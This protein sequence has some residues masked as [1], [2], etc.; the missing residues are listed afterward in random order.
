MKSS[1][2]MD[3]GVYDRQSMG[4]SYT[5]TTADEARVEDLQKGRLLLPP[6]PVWVGDLFDWT[7]DPFNDRNWRFQRHTL[8]WLMPLVHQSKLGDAGASLYTALAKSWAADNPVDDPSAP[9]TWTDMAAGTRATTLALGTRLIGRSDASWYADLL[10]LHRDWLVEE[11]N[12]GS[13]NHALHQHQGLLVVASTIRD[14][15]AQTLAVQ[16]MTEQFDVAFDDQGA[17]DEG[18]TAYHQ[19]NLRWWTDAWERVAREGLPVPEHVQSRLKK[20]SETLAHMTLPSGRLV[21]I[22]D[23]VQTRVR[24]GL[25]PSTDWLASG[26]EK[27]VQPSSKVRVLDRGY[28]LSRSGWRRDDSFVATRFGEDARYSHTHEDR[29]AVWFHSRGVTWL[30]D[31]GFRSYQNKDPRFIYLKGE[32]AHNVPFIVGL[33]ADI[34]APVELADVKHEEKYRAYKLLDFRYPGYRIVRRVVHFLDLE[35]VLVVDSADA[36]DKDAAKEVRLGQRWLVSPGLR[37]RLDDSGYRLDSKDATAVLRWFGRRTKTRLVAAEEGRLEGWTYPKWKTPV[38][39]Y[40]IT[41]TTTFDSPALAV[42]ISTGRGRDQLGVV[43]SYLNSRGDLVLSVVRG[44]EAWRI[45]VSAD[46]DTVDID[47]LD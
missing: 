30:E 19:M 1:E 9:E 33:E 36:L 41:A 10:A 6:H 8:R 16:R 39:S 24:A 18:S 20:A 15:D 38:A 43:Y 32:Q 7:A 4:A 35:A 3:L 31:G 22:G 45:D 14:G 25:G 13:G 11:E 28:V 5:P 34:D 21:Q 12:V 46:G 27:G 47:I 26:G 17:N 37:A 23:G 40:Q 42:L 29:A 2:A 44:T